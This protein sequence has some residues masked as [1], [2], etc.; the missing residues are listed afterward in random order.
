MGWIPSTLPRLWPALRQ[1]NGDKGSLSNLYH[2][3]IRLLRVFAMLSGIQ[4][5]AFASRAAH[6]CYDEQAPRD[7]ELRLN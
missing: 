6:S 5:Y 2:E 7:E 1:P 3:T 4:N